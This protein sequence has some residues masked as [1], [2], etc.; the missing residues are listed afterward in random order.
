MAIPTLLICSFI[1]LL[2]NIWVVSNFWLLCIR[3]NHAVPCVDICFI[4]PIIVM[5]SSEFVPQILLYGFLKDLPPS[6]LSCS[7]CCFL[8]V[9]SL[10]P[11]NYSN[12]IQKKNQIKSNKQLFL[13]HD[14]PLKIV[15]SI[16]RFFC[17]ALVS[18]SL[19]AHQLLLL[20]VLCAPP[21]QHL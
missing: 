21:T 8:L 9:L 17:Q 5:L 1:H 4:F 12:S 20:D 3:P 11:T 7:F 19:S 2:I 13:N 16:S 18:Q 6:S 15:F 14:T 10:Q